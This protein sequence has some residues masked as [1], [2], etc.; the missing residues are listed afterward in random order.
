MVG[1][2]VAV[3]V[4]GM[5]VSVRLREGITVEG[6]GVIVSTRLRQ[7]ARMKVSSVHAVKSLGMV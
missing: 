1:E 7:P 6:M 3:N 2:G 4:G 5:G